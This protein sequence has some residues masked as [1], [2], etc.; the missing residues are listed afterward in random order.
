MKSYLYASLFLLFFSLS[1]SQT[2]ISKKIYL[3]SLRNETDEINHKYYRIVKNYSLTQDQYVFKDYY[4]SG[5]LQM[6]GNSKS[7]DHLKHEGIF[8]FYFENGNKRAVSNYRN[9]RLE[10]K[11]FE[12][13][14]NGNIQSEIEYPDAQNEPTT[15][16][17]KINQFW[18]K[19]NTQTIVDGNGYY[20]FKDNTYSVSGKIKNGVRDGIWKEHTENP[21]N[22]YIEKYENGKF[23]SGIRVDFD[24]KEHKYYKFE[25]KPNPRNGIE[26]FYDYIRKNF[27]HTRESIEFKAEGKIYVQFVVDKTGEIIDPKILKGLGHGLDEEAIRVIRDYGYWIPGE[28]RGSKIR[29]LYTIPITVSSIR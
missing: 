11:Q 8:I 14:E 19:D 9:S 24:K 5:K 27:K 18:D 16:D 2:P 29:C 22:S 15:S 7:K 21:T 3:D 17:V 1:F 20:E 28:Q 4:K 12:W 6:V 25:T 10:G 26:D 13:Y 23:I